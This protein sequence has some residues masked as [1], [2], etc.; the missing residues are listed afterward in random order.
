M[1]K[2]KLCKANGFGKNTPAEDNAKKTFMHSKKKF[3]AHQIVPKN[4]VQEQNDSPP[5]FLHCSSSVSLIFGL[6]LNVLFKIF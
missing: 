1:Q 6:R 2:K 5:P 3:L 4:N